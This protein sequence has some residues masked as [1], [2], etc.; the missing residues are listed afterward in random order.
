MAH[1]THD[2]TY[3]SDAKAAFTGLIVGAIVLFAIVRTIVY[4]TNAKYAHERPAAEAT[5]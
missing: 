5:K 1:D 4:M 2:H 3:G